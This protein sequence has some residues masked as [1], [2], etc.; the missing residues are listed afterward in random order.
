MT[1]TIKKLSKEAEALLISSLE[2]A[3]YLVNDGMHPNDA[4]YKVASEQS[5]PAGHVKLMVHGYNNGRTISQIRGKDSLHEK[6]ADFELADAKT[7][8]D[9]MFPSEIKTANEKHNES[10]IADDY[11]L[12][13]GYW[14]QRRQ[15]EEKRAAACKVKLPAMTDKKAEYPV[16]Q[17][18]AV[19]RSMAD[20]QRMNKAAAD[21]TQQK[22]TA[23][24]AAVAALT[25]LAEYFNT[26]QCIPFPVVRD[27][28]ALVK[29]AAAKAIFKQLATKQL[30]KQA[31]CEIIP[32]DWD[33]EP[34]S[35]VVGCIKAAQIYTRAISGVKKAEQ[36]ASVKTA[37]VLA[38]FCPR[39]DK[40]VIT[41]SV[42]GDQSST[43][44][45]GVGQI[46]AG[47]LIGG[48]TKGIVG[49]LGPPGTDELV[50]EQVANLS[51]PAHESQLQGIRTKAMLNDLMANDP[52]I[53]GYAP[54]QVVDAFNQIS[55]IA[56]RV[57][58]Q[59]MMAQAL[60]RKYLEQAGTVDLYDQT[61]VLGAEK[62]LRES[63]KVPTEKQLPAPVE[64]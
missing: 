35:L 11:A 55:Q 29:G 23:K 5:L 21:A 64:Q 20:V 45:A 6:A 57:S 24:Y 56:P 31:A 37:E 1:K 53:S 59:R 25:K 51:S 14:Q 27:N 42:W 34:Y 48:A 54:D 17:E 10:S 40:R 62:Q 4:I 60:L 52:V 33:A 3:A 50:Q 22:I 63:D 2:K 13:P 61:Q 19:L 47:A 36:E 41:G 38:P 39:D 12:P 49:K 32:V 58:Q 44:E 9:R 30:E 18:K 16:Y 7:I 15:R 8:I 26:F 28:A 43:K 46:G